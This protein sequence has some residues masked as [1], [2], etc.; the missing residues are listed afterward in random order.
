MRRARREGVSVARTGHAGARAD[1]MT[2][3]NGIKAGVK[4]LDIDVCSQHVFVSHVLFGN[5][6]ETA[7]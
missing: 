7:T 5:K 6:T 4:T 3:D 2:D 1:A